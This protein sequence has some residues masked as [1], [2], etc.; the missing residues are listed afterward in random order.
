MLG[1][2]KYR[3]YL[4]SARIE[5]SRRTS[6]TGSGIPT[7]ITSEEDFF[8]PDLQVGNEPAEEQRRCNSAEKLSHDKPGNICGPDARECVAQTSCNRDGRICKRCRCGEPVGRCD[9]CANSEWN[10]VGTKPG[11]TPNDGDKAECR[12]KFTEH[13]WKA[14]P[15]RS[16]D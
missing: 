10:G 4:K 6:T 13:F 12:H 8:S 7:R 16:S 9:I 1:P 5:R 11:T 2:L 15:S 14:A 3:P